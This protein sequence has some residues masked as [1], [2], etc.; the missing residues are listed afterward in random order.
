MKILL[1]ICCANC[2]LYP[3]RILREEGHRFTGFWFN[4]NIH[5]YQEYELRLHSLKALEDTCRIDMIYPDEYNPE[6]YFRMVSRDNNNINQTQTS[7]VETDKDSMALNAENYGRFIPPPSERCTA[8]YWLRL[9]KTA[10]QAQEYGFEAFTTSLLISPYQNFEQITRAGKEL[11]EKYNVHF[12]L[13]DFRQYFR[14]AMSY[15][16]E[17]GFY[18][19]KYCGCIFSREESKK[20]RDLNNKY[21]IL[22][23]KQNKKSEILKS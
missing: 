10:Q 7:S 12:Y 8:C 4:P 9:E 19:Q 21:K 2:A 22:N 13:R 1:H 5:P 3:T 16:R 11:G 6:E 17:L 14:K 18:R 20:N 23:A 15:S